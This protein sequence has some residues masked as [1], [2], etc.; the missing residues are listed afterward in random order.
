MGMPEWTSHVSLGKLLDD[1]DFRRAR[2]IIHLTNGSENVAS[3]RAYS[4]TVEYS[5]WEENVRE[6]VSLIT[7]GMVTFQNNGV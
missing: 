5:L 2:K 1:Y 6:M 4:L 7:V 3:I